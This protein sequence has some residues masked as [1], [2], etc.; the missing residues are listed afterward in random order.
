MQNNRLLLLLSSILVIATCVLLF[1]FHPKTGVYTLNGQVVYP[2]GS[3]IS[4]PVYVTQQQDF[5][6]NFN[7]L[8]RVYTGKEGKFKT[9]YYAELNVPIHFYVVKDGLTPIKHTLYPKAE[10][11]K[12]QSLEEPILFASFHEQLNSEHYYGDKGM[13][14][15]PTFGHRCG[16]KPVSFIPVDHI[17][18]VENLAYVSCTGHDAPNLEGDIKTRSKLFSRTFFRQ[19]LSGNIYKAASPLSEK[20]N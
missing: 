1:S 16:Q 15:L 11:G 12:D 5:P 2:E 18:F 17:L 3:A 9:E 19:P 20:K 7:G 4:L 13:P 14:K 6:A 10:N 8:H